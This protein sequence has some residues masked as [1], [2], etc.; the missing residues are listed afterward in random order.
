MPPLNDQET[1]LAPPP[2]IFS[3]SVHPYV[4]YLHFIRIVYTHSELSGST[5]HCPRIFRRYFIISHFCII[6]ANYRSIIFTFHS[7][8]SKASLIIF[9]FSEYTN[10]AASDRHGRYEPPYRIGISYTSQPCVGHQR[11]PSYLEVTCKYKN[12]ERESAQLWQFVYASL[13]GTGGKTNILTVR[14]SGDG[15]RKDVYFLPQT[16]QILYCSFVT[17]FFLFI[18]NMIYVII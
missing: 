4:K 12:I 3:F 17:S 2:P 5:L 9:N 14:I 6:L 13:Q 18:Q 15:S 8:C 16:N 11:H 10:D 1:S 7:Y